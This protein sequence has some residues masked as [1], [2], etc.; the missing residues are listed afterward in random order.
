MAE[1]G[2]GC[3]VKFGTPTHHSWSHVSFGQKTC[4]W[5]PGNA[6]RMAAQKPSNW[7]FREVAPPKRTTCSSI[8]VGLLS[9]FR[10]NVERFVV[11]SSSS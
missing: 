3:P 9:D 1:A 2:P 11:S 8:I 4:T 10:F 7:I 5:A 6:D